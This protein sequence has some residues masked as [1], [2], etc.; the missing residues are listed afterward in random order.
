MLLISDVDN[1]KKPYKHKTFIYNMHIKM[2]VWDRICTSYE[3]DCLIFLNNVGLKTVFVKK[4]DLAN[5]VYSYM[6]MESLHVNGE[7][8][9]KICDPSLDGR[10]ILKWIFKKWNGGH[11]L[12]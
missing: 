12:D 1:I 2:L 6:V 8:F 3:M 11:G 5:V 7:F 10:I 9:I 4:T